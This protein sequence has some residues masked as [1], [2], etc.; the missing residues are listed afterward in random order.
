MA[1]SGKHAPPLGVITD[2]RRPWPGQT[3]PDTGL[4]SLLEAAK[5]SATPM[6]L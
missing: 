1:E 6:E 2:A 3:S 5:S 4:D